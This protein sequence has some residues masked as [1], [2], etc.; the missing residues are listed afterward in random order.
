MSKMSATLVACESWNLGAVVKQ[1]DADLQHLQGPPLRQNWH[2]TATGTATCHLAAVIVIH[3][4][5]SSLD[6]RQSLQEGGSSQHRHLALKQH[7]LDG[8]AR[9]RC[10]AGV[11]ALTM[12]IPGK[13]CMLRCRETTDMHA[14]AQHH[15]ITS[16]PEWR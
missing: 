11:G 7:L 6:P 4:T 2:D 15:R 13:L 8:K 1:D 5:R 14:P 3:D 10:D 9:A 12:H 16:P